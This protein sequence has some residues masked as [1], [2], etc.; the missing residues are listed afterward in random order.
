MARTRSRKAKSTSAGDRSFLSRRAAIVWG[1]LLAS[2]TTVGGGL[3]LLQGDPTPRM[4]G[5]ALAAPVAAMGATPI[6]AIFSTKTPVERGR[7]EGIVIH[8]SGAAF[9]NAKTIAAQHQARKLSGL[10]YHFVIGN[11]AGADD[12]ELNVGYRWL[13]QAPGAHTGG[14]GED[15][16]NSRYI[17][18]CLVGDGDRR[19]FTK[20]QMRRLAQL[21]GAL[22]SRL[23]IQPDHV[24]LHSDVAETSSPGRLFP[25]AEFRAGLVRPALAAQ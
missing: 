18:I 10:G 21:V 7:W 23:G 24:L 9:G 16:Y 22:Q 17:G 6:E 20:A 12:G 19:P 2:M 4:D 5:L 8:H 15:L 25:L 14:P 3:L 13:E 1:A 11:G